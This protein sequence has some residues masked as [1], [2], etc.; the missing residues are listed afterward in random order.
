MNISTT[1]TIHNVKIEAENANETKNST[2]SPKNNKLRH[3]TVGVMTSP[4]NA[5]NTTNFEWDV[6]GF[7]IVNT[8]VLLM[9]YK[10][11]D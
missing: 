2:V 10:S 6:F 3:N 9:S 7:K 4:G 1:K 8:F 11:T 5:K